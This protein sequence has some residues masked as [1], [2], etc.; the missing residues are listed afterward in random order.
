MKPQHFEVDYLPIFRAP[1][2]TIG[3]NSQFKHELTGIPTFIYGFSFGAPTSRLHAFMMI[4]T[5]YL[6]QAIHLPFTVN[7]HLTLHTNAAIRFAPLNSILKITLFGKSVDLIEVGFE[8]FIKKVAV[9]LK[10]LDHTQLRTFVSNALVEGG[11]MGDGGYGNEGKSQI[12]N[13]LKSF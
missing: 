1:S 5:R 13:F 4:F 6:H 3:Y 8:D 12:L 10:T 2:N 11:E 9:I 7:K